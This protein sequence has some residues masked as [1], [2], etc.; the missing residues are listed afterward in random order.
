[1]LADLQ[2]QPSIEKLANSVNLSASH[3]LKL[4]KTEVGVSPVQ[5]LRLLRL[6]KARELLEETFLQVSQI[7]FEV[8]MPDQSHF[9]RDF[10]DQYGLTPS[11]YRKQHWA[12]PTAEEYDAKK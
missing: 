11:A 5:Y 6:E 7:G 12:K 4:F 10:K 2:S 1:M 9:T 8:G 3:L